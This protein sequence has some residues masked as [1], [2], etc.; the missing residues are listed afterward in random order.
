[1]LGTNLT[2]IISQVLDLAY[3]IAEKHIVCSYTSHAGRTIYHAKVFILY[4]RF[5]K[6]IIWKSYY[7]TIEVFLNA[8]FLKE[9]YFLKDAKQHWI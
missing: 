5:L 7:E 8:Y 9:K 6:Y 1:M 2:E 3:M 4:M